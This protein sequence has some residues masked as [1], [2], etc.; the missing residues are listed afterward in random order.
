MDI[1][2]LTGEYQNR[3]LASLEKA[4]DANKH[5]EIYGKPEWLEL[6]TE[7]LENSIFQQVIYNHEEMNYN[8]DPVQGYACYLAD[9]HNLDDGYLYRADDCATTFMETL[10]FL[11]ARGLL[12]EQGQGQEYD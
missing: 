3:D 9:G 12:K 6:L 7:Y 4:K 8:H 10:K 5:I 11:E 1:T 2:D